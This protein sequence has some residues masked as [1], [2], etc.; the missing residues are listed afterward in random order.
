LY[1]FTSERYGLEAIR[2]ERLKIARIAELNDPFEFL[3]TKFANIHDGNLESMKE[4]LNLN[5]GVICFS[6]LWYHPMMWAHYADKH[7]GVALGFDLTDASFMEKVKYVSRPV[8][9]PGIYLEN[10]QFDE[11]AGRAIISTKFS[12]WRYERECRIFCSLDEK[13]PVLDLY[14]QTLSSVL[15]LTEVILGERCQVDPDRVHRLLEQRQR[16]VRVSRAERSRNSFRM[17]RE[18]I[19]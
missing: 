18:T 19:A 6:E 9:F 3:A 17:L 14:F 2:D 12:S 11:E 8:E 5:R 4:Q 10:G 13:D 7:K 15:E 16:K 1:Y